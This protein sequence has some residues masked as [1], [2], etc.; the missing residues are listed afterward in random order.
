MKGFVEFVKKQGVVGLAVG[1]VL[2]GSVSNVVSSLTQDIINPLL[3]LVFGAA[4]NLTNLT[5][6]LGKV[7]LA[8]GHFLATFVDFLVLSFVVYLVVTTLK[9]DETSIKKK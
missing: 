7:Q 1:F 2:G 4:D 3:S 8:Y 5:L 6:S 9:L